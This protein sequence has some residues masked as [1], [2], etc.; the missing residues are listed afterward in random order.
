MGK[1]GSANGI[2]V[3]MTHRTAGMVYK[4]GK[5]KSSECSLFPPGI[6]LGGN[7]CSKLDDYLLCIVQRGM[8]SPKRKML[9]QEEIERALEIV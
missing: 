3:G 4:V 8:Y 5:L 2:I 9:W 7:V 6:L 1:K